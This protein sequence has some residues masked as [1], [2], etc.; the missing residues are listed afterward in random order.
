QLLGVACFDT[1]E[2]SR[3]FC[4]WRI[5]RTPKGAIGSELQAERVA[6]G[7]FLIEQGVA[8]KPDVY[9][10][11]VREIPNQ[12]VSSCALR[13]VRRDHNQ[14][15]KRA[16][17]NKNRPSPIPGARPECCAPEQHGSQREDQHDQS[18]GVKWLFEE[19]PRHNKRK[20]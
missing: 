19:F 5:S 1:T 11:A 13:G 16:E 15:G 8:D 17:E 9:R 18:H 3:A 10:Q 2:I 6:A 4:E 20:K 14:K 12:L 7:S